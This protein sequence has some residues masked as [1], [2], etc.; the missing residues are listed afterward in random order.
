MTKTAGAAERVGC[1][2]DDGADVYADFNN[3]AGGH[4]VTDARWFRDRL[5]SD[6]IDA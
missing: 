2:L 5:T 6:D 3:D 4:A 1:W